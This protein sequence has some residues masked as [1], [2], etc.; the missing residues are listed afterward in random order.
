MSNTQDGAKRRAGI[1]DASRPAGENDSLGVQ[2]RNVVP[3]GSVVDQLAVDVGFA[4]S[5][6]DQAAVLG[7]EVDDE[8]RLTLR[9][10]MRLV[11]PSL[12]R[13][14]L[15]FFCVCRKV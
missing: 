15:E 2:V 9:V 13:R 7:T 4:H 8:D 6:G 3:T 14:F 5:T 10:M 11:C 1:I 12:P